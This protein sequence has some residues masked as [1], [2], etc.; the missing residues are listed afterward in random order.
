MA[1]ACNWGGFADTNL[2]VNEFFF[3]DHT[4][5]VRFLLQYPNSYQ[6]PMAAVHGTGSLFVGQGDFDADP[7][8]AT[9]KLLVRLGNSQTTVPVNFAAN[10]WHHLAL[11]RAGTDVSLFLDGQP[12]G[13]PLRLTSQAQP[14]GTLRFGKD[15][16]DPNLDGGGRQFYGLLDDIA[17][18]TA[19]LSAAEVATLAATPHLS[20]TEPNLL[21]GYVFGDPLQGGPPPP[22]NRPLWLSVGASLVQVSAN[23][24]GAA[25][26]AGIPLCSTSLTHLPFPPGQAW[27]V[28]QGFDNPTGSHRGYAAFCH[29]L[30]LAGQPQSAS[31]G[32][33]FVAGAPGQVDTVTQSAAPGGA[34]NYL[35]VR[36]RQLEF[37]DYLHL[38]QNSAQVAVGDQVGFDQHLADVGDTGA[39]VGAFHLHRAVTNLGEGNKGS[40]GAFVTIPAPLANYEVSDNQGQTW[41]AVIRGIPTPG[42]WLRRSTDTNPV[43]YTAAWQPSNEGEIQVY[44]WTYADYRAK[45]DELW[46]QGWRLK[47]LAPYI[48]GG[49]VRY[50]ATWQPSSEGEIQVYGWTYADYRAKYDE[51][52]PQG[53]RLKLLASYVVDG[54]VRYTA[55]WQPS[56]EGEIQVYGWTYPDYRAKYDELW[57]QGW[58]L[59]LLS[60]YIG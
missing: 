26:A 42:Q 19:A 34:T 15:T 36:Q 35:S 59:K 47:H 38:V 53:W 27:Q 28:I 2:D 24:D 57:P 25:D 37:G 40:G 18:F 6:G 45:Y 41:R 52:W 32:R 60:P 8:G 58:R 20:G 54:D 5:T 9:P 29:D 17:V 50:T 4:L 3:N 14:A 49:G 11:V 16:F 39:A 31:N 1:L 33:P 10:S 55:V 23:R 12:I 44:G 30:I 51:L 48:V 13:A 43:R 21:A 56:S 22:L 7:P 46:P